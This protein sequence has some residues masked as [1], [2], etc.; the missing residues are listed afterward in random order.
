[1]VAHS[2]GS[3]VAYEGLCA[4]PEWRVRGLVTLGSPLA[5]RNVILDRLHPSPQQ[6]AGLWR[7]TWPSPLTSWA[8][9]ADRADFVALE[10]RLRPVFGEKVADTEISNGARMH[11]VARYLTAAETGAAI[12]GTLHGRQAGRGG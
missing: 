10:K 6:V 3:V 2:L 7:A 4:H 12:A 11:H 8:N 9:I 5:I 1:V